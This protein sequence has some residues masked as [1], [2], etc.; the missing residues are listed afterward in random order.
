MERE[1]GGDYDA[2]HRASVVGHSL[3]VVVAAADKDLIEAGDCGDCDYGGGGAV[4]VEAAVAV[5]DVAVGVGSTDVDDVEVVVV[6]VGQ[7]CLEE[8]NILVIGRSVENPFVELSQQPES[9]RAAVEAV[10]KV[11]DFVCS[12]AAADGVGMAERMKSA[13]SP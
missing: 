9:L 11:G 2:V 13:F 12:A 10:D 3:A 6:V 8:S 5:A 4:V 7:I 1:N